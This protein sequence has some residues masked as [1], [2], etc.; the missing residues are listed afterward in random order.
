V[1]G[2]LSIGAT[3][4]PLEVWVISM[5]DGAFRTEFYDKTERGGRVTVE[6]QALVLEYGVYEPGDP[7]CCPS[8]LA[9]ERVAWDESLDRIAV[10]SLPA[11]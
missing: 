10:Q 4:G 9:R 11:P 6:R 1:V 8:G 5:S 2:V 3:A 7:G